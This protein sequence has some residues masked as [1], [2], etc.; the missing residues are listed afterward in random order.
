M[1][2]YPSLTEEFTSPLPPAELLRRVQTA[3]DFR[4]DIGA[5]GF[6]LSR[7][8]D[9]RNSMLP[10]IEGWVAAGAAG[11]SRLRLRHSLPPLVLVF[12]AVWLFFVGSVV[13]AMLPLLTKAVA[14]GQWR[15]L[16]GPELIPLGMLG[17]G[18]LLLTVPFWVEVRQSRPQLVE[19]LHLHATAPGAP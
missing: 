6:T 2:F 9:Y 17:F 12:G 18:V 8:V 4:G 15:E 1:R 7:V 11:G 19:L 13:A 16:L 5:T 10:R 14:A 3:R